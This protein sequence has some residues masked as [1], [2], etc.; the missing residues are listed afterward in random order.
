[1]RPVCGIPGPNAVVQVR[2]NRRRG[3]GKRPGEEMVIVVAGKR[4]FLP[5]GKKKFFEI[6]LCTQLTAGKLSLHLHQYI[7]VEQ[8]SQ[9]SGPIGRSGFLQ[10]GHV[11]VTGIMLGCSSR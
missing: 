1:M 5:G 7:V 6:L 11:A 8:F 2:V 3:D 4:Q 9:Y 10:Q